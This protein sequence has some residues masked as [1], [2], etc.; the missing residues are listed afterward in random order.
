MRR[1]QFEILR[2]NATAAWPPTLGGSEPTIGS[3]TSAILTL[4]I[5][6]HTSTI[7]CA[8]DAQNAD[9]NVPNGIEIPADK[10]R[11]PGTVSR[12]WAV[13]ADETASSGIAVRHTQMASTEAA[14]PLAICQSAALKN[15]DIS[16]R[17]K[18]LHGARGGGGV[19]FR[20]ATP[21]VYY[22]VRIDLLRNMATL[23]LVN[24]RTEEEVIAVDAGVDFDA[25]QTLTVRAQDER[26]T[27]FLNGIWIFTGYDKTLAHPGLIALWAEPGGTTLFD[28]ITTGPSQ[29]PSVGPNGL[30]IGT[31][32]F[33]NGDKYV[34]EMSYGALHGQG[35][36]T[37]RNGD[38]YVG[39]FKRGKRTGNGTYAFFGGDSFVG[40]VVD[41]KPC[42]YGVYRFA[43]GSKLVGEFRDGQLITY[44]RH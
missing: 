20:M 9:G 14:E 15:S 27:V 39:E 16:V 38:K 30:P 43:N 40:N 13:V 25:W 11:P 2:G 21:E 19:A 29:G 5:L 6:L 18:A 42:G 24:N 34:G 1:R 7:A 3:L 8:A 31:Y 33:A 17:F 44:I 37:F 32:T 4:L 22:L 26:F 41:G 28:R 23:V 35:T 12:S 10:C 36:Y